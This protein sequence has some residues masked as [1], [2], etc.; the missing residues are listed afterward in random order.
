[1][2]Q[3]TSEI[4]YSLYSSIVLLFLC[5]IVSTIN[6]QRFTPSPAVYLKGK[7]VGRLYDVVTVDNAEEKLYMVD[8]VGIF[9]RKIALNLPVFAMGIKQN[10]DCYYAPYWSVQAINEKQNTAVIELASSITGDVYRLEIKRKKSRLYVTEAIMF[11]MNSTY[12]YF[13]S[14]DDVISLN[15]VQICRKKWNKPIKGVIVFDDYFKETND[16][17]SYYCP[18]KYPLEVCLQMMRQGHIFNPRDFEE[19]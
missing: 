13:L 4:R 17:E 16:F 2:G 15:A 5:V 9:S 18:R 3:Q 11:W 6:A 1:M 14:K 10:D 7:Y 8:T 12:N 19:E